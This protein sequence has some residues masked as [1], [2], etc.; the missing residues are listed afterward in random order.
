[1]VGEPARDEVESATEPSVEELESLG[2]PAG[3]DPA[4]ALRWMARHRE[5]SEEARL[6]EL[7]ALGY[8]ALFCVALAYE[9]REGSPPP[10]VRMFDEPLHSM[11]R[12]SQAVVPTLPALWVEGL[13][14]AVRPH[15]LDP[16]ERSVRALA[17]SLGVEELVDPDYDFEGRP[18]GPGAYGCTSLDEYAKWVRAHGRLRSVPEPTDDPLGAIDRL[19]ESRHLALALKRVGRV[20]EDGH[21]MLWSL[22]RQ[23]LNAVRGLLRPDEIRALEARCPDGIPLSLPD[24][25]WGYVRDLMRDVDLRWDAAAM[26][27]VRR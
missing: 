6:A 21:S 9:P 13:P 18:F 19:E 7:E 24:D 3:N 20:G 25:V 12:V 16:E 11:E 8:G 17:R 26:A 14:F 5:R 4:L 23:A 15:D 1:M 10:P 22:R 2:T 27:Y